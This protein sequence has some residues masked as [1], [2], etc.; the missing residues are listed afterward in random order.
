MPSETPDRARAT[1]R[2]KRCSSTWMAAYNE[3]RTHQGRWCFGKTPTQN[4]LDS[5]DVGRVK[6]NPIVAA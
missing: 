3:Q 6:Q 1:T 5:A 4:F 2:R